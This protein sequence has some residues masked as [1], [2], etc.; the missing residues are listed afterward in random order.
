MLT[1]VIRVDEMVTMPDLAQ[2]NRVALWLAY[3]Y[4]LH[5]QGHGV[6]E[7]ERMADERF[8]YAPP[9]G[10]LGD[11]MRRESERQGNGG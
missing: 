9:R 1:S 3:F 4:R 5:D 10:S 8:G 7:A 6:V 2:V 11:Q